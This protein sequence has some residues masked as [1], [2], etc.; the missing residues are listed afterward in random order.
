MGIKLITVPGLLLFRLH[1]FHSEIMAKVGLF[2]K[3]SD[4]VVDG[5]PRTFLELYRTTFCTLK[6]LQKVGQQNTDS[7]KKLYFNPEEH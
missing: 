3:L 1:Y 5:K 2:V 4:K 6:S 7:F